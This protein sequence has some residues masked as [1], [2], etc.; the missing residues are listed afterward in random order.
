MKRMVTIALALLLVASALTSAFANRPSFGDLQSNDWFLPY[1]HFVY[2]NKV[3]QGTSSTTFS[4]QGGFTRAQVVATL[5]RMYFGRGASADEPRGTEFNDVP[6][7]EWFAPYVSWASTNDIV[8]GIGNNRFAPGDVVERQ[9]LATMIYRFAD[10]LTDMDTSIQQSE[11]WYSFIDQDQIADWAIDTLV[12][13]HYHGLITGRSATT[14]APTASVS[15]AEAAA[16]LS[17][18]LLHINPAPALSP[19]LN[20]GIREAYLQYWQAQGG[21]PEYAAEDL[22]IPFIVAYSNGLVAEIFR[23]HLGP[24][25]VI[26]VDVGGYRFAFGSGEI[27]LFF[28]HLDSSDI[29]PF[30]VAF[31][32]GLISSEELVDILI[33]RSF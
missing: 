9:Q 4:P 22:H 19:E 5:F 25:M 16:L 2:I 8:E 10:R 28:Y 15:R 27:T 6:E 33:R 12:W 3:M 20:A 17:R 31:E 29:M 24:P 1:A 7:S 14:L 30:D 11:H 21:T 13:A 26:F 18:V 23:P 32:R